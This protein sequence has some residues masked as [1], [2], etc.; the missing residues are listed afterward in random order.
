[1][2][3]QPVHEQH[4][5]REQDALA[6]IRN[7]EDVRQLVKH[8]CP[9]FTVMTSNLPPA[10]VIFSWADFEN[11]CALTVI[12]MVSSPSPRI[13]T[14]CFVLITPA[15][16]RTSGVMVVSPSST[17]RSKLTMLNS[18]RK[19]LVKP[20]FGM[21]RCSGIWP[22]S[23]PRIMRDPVRERCP[24]CP[25]V[26]VL[27]IPEPM[28]RPTRLRFSVAFFGA[29]MFDKFITS[30]V[31]TLLATSCPR[32]RKSCRRPRRSKL[33]LYKMLLHK[34]HQMRHL[35][36]H[37]TNGLRVRTL[38][39]LVQPGESQ[40]LDHQLLFHRGTNGGAHP[41]QLDLST[42]RIR[43]LRRHSLSL[44]IHNWPRTPGPLPLP[45]NS[46]AVLPRISATLSRLFSCF[47]ASNVALITLCGLV[48][49]MDFVSTFCTPAD[50]IT[51][52][53]APPAITPVPSGAGFSRTLPEP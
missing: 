27:P 7:A 35:G 30:F 51:A 9:A 28:P 38:N 13:F 17:S 53:T 47:S 26:D 14:G 25:R 6:Q 29:R 43:F 31:E 19:M 24:L 1:M 22:P 20:R 16:R 3:A 49:P 39:H 44:V 2:P 15:L 37:A 23:K 46:C 12:A 8:Y 5:Q 36:Y 42:A 11:L 4:R 18:L 21:R 45:Y 41:F 40:S 32:P 33:R 48:V 34:L 10:L 52:R 50:V